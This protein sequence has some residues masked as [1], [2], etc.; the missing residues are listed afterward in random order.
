MTDHTPV[1]ITRIA[2]DDTRSIE[3]AT[4]GKELALVRGERR[5]RLS[6]AECPH[7]VE[8]HDGHADN[9]SR[10][11]CALCL[12]RFADYGRGYEQV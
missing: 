4:C 11:S 6:Q 2:F 9:P 5:H 10:Y 7:P 1:P 3:C 12:A 8:A